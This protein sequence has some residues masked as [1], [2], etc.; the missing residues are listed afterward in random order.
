MEAKVME[1]TL[2]DNS[3]VYDVIIY[4]GGDRA[5]LTCSDEV[6]ANQV[7]NFLNLLIV[8][9]KILDLSI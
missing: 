4:Q 2:T 6:T 7:A 5:V 1:S 9:H 8:K 3:K